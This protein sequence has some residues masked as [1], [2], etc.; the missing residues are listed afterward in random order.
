M[1]PTDRPAWPWRLLAWVLLVLGAAISL[2]A[3][4]V[5]PI[6]GLVYIVLAWTA[7]GG[8][9]A[10][11]YGRRARPLWFWRIFAPL[12]SLYTMW[13]LG[14]HSGRFVAALRNGPEMSGAHISIFVVAVPL[15]I[16]L[17]IAL[18]RH[19]QLLRGGQ[20]SAMRDLEAVFA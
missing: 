6:S 18:L 8:V 11:A 3:L 13:D 12:L 2:P 7:L 20:R 15:N 16:L 9:L 19:A 14:G 1:N 17:C 10:Y 4:L 5:T